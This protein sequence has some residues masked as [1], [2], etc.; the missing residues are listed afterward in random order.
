MPILRTEEEERDI[1]AERSEEEIDVARCPAWQ[2]CD[3]NQMDFV[4]SPAFHSA[5]TD[6]IG[7]FNAKMWVCF[8]YYLNSFSS[9]RKKKIGN[10]CP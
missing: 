8:S 6:V 7:S 1:L 2:E 3:K 10:D 4:L 9:A 5:F